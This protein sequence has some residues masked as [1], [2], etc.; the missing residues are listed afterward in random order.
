[1]NIPREI[2]A[3]P[4]VGKLSATFLTVFVLVVIWIS[5]RF[6]IAAVR[7]VDG[8]NTG[9]ENI[10]PTSWGMLAFVGIIILCIGKAASNFFVERR[11][12]WNN[13]HD[14]SVLSRVTLA[15]PRGLSVLWSIFDWLLVKV[16]SPL[17]GA[18]IERPTLR[19][20]TL[21]LTSFGALLT[22]DNLEGWKSIPVLSVLFLCLLGLIRRWSWVEHD[23]DVFLL[24]RGARSRETSFRIGFKNDLRDETLTAIALIMLA[25]PVSFETLQSWSC[26]FDTGG[27]AFGTDTLEVEAS[28]LS[29]KLKWIGF[30]GAELVK[31]LPFVDWSE[32]FNVAN[33]SPIVVRTPLGAQFVFWVRASLDILFVA[34]IFQVFQLGARNREQ[35]EAFR[36]GRLQVLEPFAEKSEIATAAQMMSFGHGVSL[37]ETSAVQN[38][39]PYDRL[40]LVEIMK[41]IESRWDDR[42]RILAGAVL[43]RQYPDQETGKVFT[44]YLPILSTRNLRLVHELQNIASGLPTSTVNLPSNLETLVGAVLNQR[45]EK[46]DHENALISLI[47]WSRQNKNTTG[48]KQ[49]VEAEASPFRTKAT[50]MASISNIEQ[51]C[52]TRILRRLIRDGIQLD[53]VD[54]VNSYVSLGYAGRQNVEKLRN[55]QFLPQKLQKA[56]SFG[57]GLLK[58]QMATDSLSCGPIPILKLSP[59]SEADSI[60]MG[61]HPSDD[62]A[63]QAEHPRHEV[64]FKHDFLISRTAITQTEFQ[65]FKGVLFTDADDSLNPR[66]PAVR[67]SWYEANAFCRWLTLVIGDCVRLPSEAEWEYA[68]RGGAEARFPWGNDWDSSLGNCEDESE[69]GICPVDKFPPNAFGIFGMNGNTY[70]WCIDPWH[71]TYDGKPNCIGRPWISGGE[72]EH[73]VVRGGS[74]DYGPQDARSSYR[75]RT[76]AENASDIMGLRIVIE[77]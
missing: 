1:M 75:Y 5:H 55:L 49:V 25:I 76:F 19:Y 33:G 66:M 37:V 53:Q 77:Q 6:S 36:S 3:N 52:E 62:L 8:S 10:I 64:V 48:L 39:P 71:P 68:C 30:F 32:V 57:C 27:C 18:T 60:M 42:S 67:V 72:F 45:S 41:N 14:G 26:Q 56:I 70:E 7:Q 2:I 28:W 13:Q 44:D 63:Y 12:L 29:T 21:L 43:Q 35:L 24:E 15:L 31:T 51:R 4:S 46:L 65:A 23:R 11:S 73:K 69:S 74:W 50:C 34:S 61:A 58:E 40:R 22:A 9:A 20:G 54:I 47:A 17:V 38:F 16:F 59:T